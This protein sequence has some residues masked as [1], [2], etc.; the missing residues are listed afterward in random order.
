MS[1][2]PYQQKLQTKNPGCIIFMVDQSGSMTTAHPKTEY[3]LA[4]AAKRATDVTITEI[5]HACVKNAETM[6]RV[7]IGAYGYSTMNQ[8]DVKWIIKGKQYDT[9]DHAGLINIVDLA[10]IED[11][12]YEPESELYIVDYVEES[13]NGGTPMGKAFD[14]VLTLVENFAQNHPNAHPPI[15]INISDG[16]PTDMSLADME[17]KAQ[18]LRSIATTD[19]ETLLW[20]IH[21]SATDPNPIICPDAGTKMPDAYADAMLASASSIPD[22]HRAIAKAKNIDLGETAKCCVY[23]ADSDTLI[24]MLSFASSVAGIDE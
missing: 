4:Y 7:W 22:S 11:E 10:D 24:K 12:Y 13:G 2:P 6:P 9:A 19:G 1:P 20:N 17:A 21:V 3:S 5:L 23:N 16:E 8:D 18:A 15:I 14:E